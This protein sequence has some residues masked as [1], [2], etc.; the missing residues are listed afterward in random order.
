[1]TNNTKIEPKFRPSF[2]TTFSYSPLSKYFFLSQSSNVYLYFRLSQI[3][4][5]SLRY[6]I[7]NLSSNLLHLSHRSF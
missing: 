4:V 3:L 1:M 6:F 5:I 7:I 2:S